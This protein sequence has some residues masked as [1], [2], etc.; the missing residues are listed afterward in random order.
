MVVHLGTIGSLHTK[1][2]TEKIGKK[3]TLKFRII[4]REYRDRFGSRRFNRK[5]TE[6]RAET[7]KRME[8]SQQGLNDSITC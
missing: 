6:A 3:V 4:F 1:R 5:T 7:E 8:S 2:S